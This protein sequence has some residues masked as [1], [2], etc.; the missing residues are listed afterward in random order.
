MTCV[1]ERLCVACGGPTLPKRRYCDPCRP[2]GDADCPYL[3]SPAEIVAGCRAA[4]AEWSE[5]EWLIRGSARHLLSGTR[6]R[7]R[8][9]RQ[10]ESAAERWRA[11]IEAAARELGGEHAAALAD[12]WRPDP[13]VW[14]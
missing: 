4:Q 7:G 1:I 14:T 5:A 6:A 9:E 13:S 8:S 2:G 11:E 10:Q 12:G 3:P